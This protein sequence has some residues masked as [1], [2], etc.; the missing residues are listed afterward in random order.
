MAE[1]MEVTLQQTYEN[2][3]CINR[4]NYVATGTPAATTLSFAL[5][6][7]MGFLPVTTTLTDGTVGGELQSLQNGGVF[8]DQCIARAVYLDDDF[9]DSPFLANTNGAGSSGANAMTPINAWGFKSSRVKQ[10]IGR[11][12]KRFVGMGEDQVGAGGII[13][14]GAQTQ[15]GV[16]ASAMGDTLSFDDEGTTLTFIPAIVQKEK[17][18]TPSGKFAYKY[19]AS[20]ATQL[21]HSAQGISWVGYAETRSQ[22]SRQYGRGQ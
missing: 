17:Y 4:W 19:Y 6:S 9:Y 12:Y 11:G 20:E 8:F 13:V 18:T 5:L 7:A 2:Q 22:V 1:I 16:L 14:S 10:S 3:I 15:M 21:L